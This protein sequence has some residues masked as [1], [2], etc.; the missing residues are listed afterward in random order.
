M[1]MQINPGSIIIY[2]EIYK[3]V[4][5]SAWADGYFLIQGA[6]LIRGPYNFFKLTKI[7]K[8]FFIITRIKFKK[9]LEKGNRGLYY[10][11]EWGSEFY[12]VYSTPDQ[13]A[14]AYL[15]KTSNS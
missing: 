5:L 8:K 11:Y 15:F 10:K 1:Q 9:G 12:L 6:I 14:S 7:K 4:Y 3:Y 13:S 2:M